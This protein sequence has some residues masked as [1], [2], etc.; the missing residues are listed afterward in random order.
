L[1]LVREEDIKF[2]TYINDVVSWISFLKSDKRFSKIILLGHSEG[3]LIG[4]IAA[5]KNNVSAFV[6]I[7]GVGRT[8][9][10]VIQDQLKTKI[11]PQL[12]QE[13]NRILDSL[14]NGKTVS[15]MDQ[16]LLFLYRPSV[17]P[18][19]ISWIKYDPSKEISKLRIPVLIIQGTNDL[20]VTVADANLLKS[21]RPGAK[22]AIIDNMNHVLK[23]CDRDM[24]KTMASYSN[25]ALPLKAGLV[26]EIAEFIK[27]AK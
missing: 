20:Q 11:P 9:D 16:S 23:E 6:S 21:A 7:A 8:A 18:Y 14:R 19:M 24:Q 25:P 17:Q 13:S 3:S 26:K 4:I 5:E 10:K 15:K 22:I 12:I 2:E 27:A 1:A